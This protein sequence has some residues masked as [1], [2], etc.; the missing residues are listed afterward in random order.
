MKKIEATKKTI[1]VG[2]K[3]QSFVVIDTVK[4]PK[5]SKISPSEELKFR[6]KTRN[7]KLVRLPDPTPDSA[8]SGINRLPSRGDN[9]NFGLINTPKSQ[10][11]EIVNTVE[12]TSSPST[13]RSTKS[14]PK[15]EGGC[16]GCSRRRAMRGKRE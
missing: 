16:S 13:I 7:G 9:P 2:N 4:E 8:P 1:M 15:K 10:S 3:K 12:N 6:T 5:R 11:S 14:A